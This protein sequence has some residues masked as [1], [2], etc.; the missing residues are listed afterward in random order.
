MGYKWNN[1]L[2][3]LSIWE[4]VF[5]S[6]LFESGLCFLKKL[7]NLFQ[8]ERCFLFALVKYENMFIWLGWH[9]MHNAKDL[10]QNNA[11]FFSKKVSNYFLIIFERLLLY[12]YRCYWNKW[13]IKHVLF[14]IFMPFYFHIVHFRVLNNYRRNRH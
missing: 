14:I 11:F 12:S 5:Q 9:I 7:F 8:F 6:S 4:K 2:Q 1:F 10:C 3:K 13:C